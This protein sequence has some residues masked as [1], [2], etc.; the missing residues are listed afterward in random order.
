MSQQDDDNQ[1][2]ALGLIATI[3]LAVVAFAIGMGIYKSHGKSA[4]KKADAPVAAVAAAAPAASVVASAAPAAAGSAAAVPADAARVVV[5]SG[6][7]KFYF[8]SGKTDIAADSAAALV[9][10]AS[11]VGSGKKAVVS[12]YADATGD[13]KKN[14]ELSKLRAFAVRDALLA[15]KVPADKIELRKPAATTGNAAG[16]SADARRVDVTLE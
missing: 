4:P 2:F 16:S 14:A 8:A 13:A 1:N 9:G 15:M 3:V 7:V 12:G 5:E 11:G 6:V 10:V